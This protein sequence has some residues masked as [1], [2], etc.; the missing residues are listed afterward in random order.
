MADTDTKSRLTLGSQFFWLT[1]VLIVLVVL[2]AVGTGVVQGQRLA[3][4]SVDAALTRSTVTQFDI[5]RLRAREVE[6]VSEIL[7]GDT[8]VTSYVAEAAAQDVLGSIA[9]LLAE[10]QSEYQFDL[11]I[12][13][14][15]EGQVLARTDRPLKADEDLSDDTLVRELINFLA[16]VSAI[17]GEGDD[18]YQ[19]AMTPMDQNFTLI[20]FLVVGKRIDANL[21][22]EIKNATGTEQIWVNKSGGIVTTTLSDD[23]T[24][25]I[26]DQLGGMGGSLET[27]LGGE[28]EA[29]R[30]EVSV[31]GAQ[32]MLNAEPVALDED[33]LVAAVIT[34]VSVDSLMAPYRRQAWILAAVG[35]AAIIAGLAL[36]LWLSRKLAKPLG[37]LTQAATAAGGGHYEQHFDHSGSREIVDLGNAFE[38]LLSDLREKRD[39]EEYVSDLSRYLPDPAF[40]QS[41]VTRTHQPATKPGREQLALLALDYRHMVNLE[42]VGSA[43][44]NVRQFQSTL[45]QIAALAEALEARL[46]SFTGHRAVIGF[47]GDEAIAHALEFAGHVAE[48]A[49][50]QPSKALVMGQVDRG[51]VRAGMSSAEVLIGKASHQVD[52]LLEE[53]QPGVLLFSPSIRDQVSELLSEVDGQPMVHKGRIS[54]RKYL[55][56][57]N[58]NLSHFADAVSSR[59]LKA[60]RTAAADSVIE[61]VAKTREIVP[62]DVFAGR[63][64]IVSILGQGGM[65]MVYKA[66]DRELD[67]F[68][69]L[70]TLLPSMA[71]NEGYLQ[72]LKEEIKLARIITHPNV[73][74]TFDF[75]SSEGTAYISMEY[76][77]G[78]TLKYLMRQRSRLPFSAGLRIIRQTCAGLAAA[79]EKDVV[80]RDIK[81]ENIILE[82]AGNAKLMD[83]GIA[84]PVQNVEASSGVFFGTPRYAAPEQMEGGKVDAH[85][86][87]YACGI[88]IYELFGGN[89]PFQQSDMMEIY[90]AKTSAAYTP[91]KEVWEECPPALETVVNC[92]LSPDVNTRYANATALSAALGSLRG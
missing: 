34:G 18:L 54:G 80:H 51:M 59:T 1:A 61:S 75:G 30:R 73:L 41:T 91:L 32:W 82:A 44:E 49:S 58:D 87:V 24:V 47:R 20:G 10:R 42:Q 74:R 50:D 45:S 6:L 8:A 39:M 92:C 2:F 67:D 9:D 83:F 64:E 25:Q 12:V 88:I 60:D 76:V 77:R 28:A 86:D 37:A 65:G 4:A 21:S 71:N 81:P 26:I 11:A 3:A 19:V 84:Q 62:G 56:L 40:E 15:A 55:A 16:P 70:K 17:W 53:A 22:D 5:E 46:E 7:A 43:E 38:T 89:T 78:M 85:A 36:S 90:E 29:F 33:T 57:N 27:L 66:L 31:G 63:F 79:H 72:Q 23:E 68:V 13:M 48:Y 52:L 69:A 35:L 14:D